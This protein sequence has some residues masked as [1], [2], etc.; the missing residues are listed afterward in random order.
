MKKFSQKEYLEFM[1]SE[2]SAP[3]TLRSTVKTKVSSDLNP[4]FLKVFVSLVGIHLV[5][6]TLTLLVC[7][8][9]GVGPIGGWLDLMQVV[10]PLGYVACALFCGT[11]YLGST[12]IFSH[13]FLSADILRAMERTRLAHFGFLAAFSMALFM[14]LPKNGAWEL[15]EFGFGVVWLVGGIFLSQGLFHVLSVRKGLG[16]EPV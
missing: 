10:M 16:L 9:F 5:S 11:L 1:T 4:S 8:Q 15:P 6:G 3:D 13:L 14:V 2:E 7:P 12:A